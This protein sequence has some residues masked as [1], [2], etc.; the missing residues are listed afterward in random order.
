MK[1]KYPEDKPEIAGIQHSPRATHSSHLS[2]W[3]LQFPSKERTVECVSP[4]ALDGSSV[5]GWN[6]RERRCFSL[7]QQP[8]PALFQAWLL[9]L[10]VPA[11]S[12]QL[13]RHRPLAVRMHN[14]VLP[15]PTSLDEF[16]FLSEGSENNC[17]VRNTGKIVHPCLSA[18]RG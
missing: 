10:E 9:S 5:G 2:C 16:T 18:P 14:P 11:P 4:L 17:S 3:P 7:C 13:H 8:L 6:S 12:S 1:D 15:S